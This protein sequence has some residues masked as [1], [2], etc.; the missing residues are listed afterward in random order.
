MHIA[1]VGP[2]VSLSSKHRCVLRQDSN[3]VMTCMDHHDTFPP[4]HPMIPS[5]FTLRHPISSVTPSSSTHS[6]PFLPHQP[7]AIPQSPILTLGAHP[8]HQQHP[9]VPCLSCDRLYVVG[10]SLACH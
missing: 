3:I 4:L 7:W 9:H 6:T 1:M 10:V 5:V 8:S 2:I